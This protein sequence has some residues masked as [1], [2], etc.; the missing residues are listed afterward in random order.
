MIEVTASMAGTIIDILVSIGDEISVG[1]E[2]IILESMKMEVPV[3]AEQKGTVTE[4]KANV[5]DF[6]NEGE[7]I[8]VLS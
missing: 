3:S 7:V 5:G 6:V 8:L 2:V 4:V 1:Q